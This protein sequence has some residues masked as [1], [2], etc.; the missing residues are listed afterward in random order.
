MSSR[1]GSSR[2]RYR[3]EPIMITATRSRAA[4]AVGIAGAA[5]LVPL[6]PAPPAVAGTTAG[7]IVYIKDYNVWIARGD[8]TGARQLATDG[9]KGGSPT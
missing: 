5:L 9:R 8:G 1:S 3:K 7:S 2:S 6:T 4:L